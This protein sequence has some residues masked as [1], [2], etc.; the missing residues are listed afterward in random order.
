MDWHDFDSRHKPELPDKAAMIKFISEGQSYLRG[1][2]DKLDDGDLIVKRKWHPG[3]VME[4]RW[5]ISAMIEHDLYHAGEIN[6]IRA[7]LQGNDA[8]PD[9]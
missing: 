8:W 4:T 1:F 6:H 2:V 9:Y 3:P 7:L 5:L